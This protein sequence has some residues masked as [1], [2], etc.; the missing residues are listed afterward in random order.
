MIILN[1]FVYFVVENGF[2]GCLRDAKLNGQLLPWNGNNSV[3]SSGRSYGVKRSC[4]DSGA[5]KT[6]KCPL[7]SD[8]I[9]TLSSYRCQCM[10]GHTGTFCKATV[11]CTD[12][13]CRNGGTCTYFKANGII[14]YRCECRPPYTGAQCQT[15]SGL[16]ASNPC[17][18][19]GKCENINDGTNY[20]CKCLPR[21]HGPNCELD[22]D[23]CA[24]SPCFFGA[25]CTRV[26]YGFKCDCPPGRKGKRCGYGHYCK[27]HRCGVGGKCTETLDGPVCECSKGYKG[28]YC[29]FDVNECLLKSTQCP[30]YS[31]C[32][33]TV[34]SYFCNCTNSL[35]CKEST[36]RRTDGG[37]F[38]MI[39][40]VYW[41]ALPVTGIIIIML[42]IYCFRK[43]RSRQD[44]SRNTLDYKYPQVECVALGRFA[45][46]VPPRFDDVPPD[47]YTDGSADFATTALYDPSQDAFSPQSTVSGDS[48]RKAPQSSIELSRKLQLHTFK[49]SPS[50]GSQ[51]GGADAADAKGSVSDVSD[52]GDH[53]H[54]PYHWDYS[55]VPEDVVN[56]SKPNR[57]GSKEGSRM[58]LSYNYGYEETPNIHD[59]VQDRSTGMLSYEIASQFSINL[60][61]SI[62]F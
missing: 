44:I 56:R 40:L 7:F 25:K 13:P 5:C 38:H 48:C 33:N 49:A 34:G 21:Y 39:N 12:N 8:C 59:K 23:P 17:K 30:A 35:N 51:R 19:G 61:W 22:N 3:I 47:Y 27:H 55:E 45:P 4:K 37:G 6:T 57:S 24:S 29:Q 28:T 36:S 46:E 14:E 18:N 16:C 52:S 9:N 1:I 41:I 50:L 2:R 60:H 26:Q 11:T 10:P 58:G 53:L 31:N 20:Q 15:D 43:R 32:I 62:V 42:A 54:G